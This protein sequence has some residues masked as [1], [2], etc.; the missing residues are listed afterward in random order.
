MIDITYKSRAD[1]ARIL[2]NELTH[3]TKPVYSPDNPKK[4]VGEPVY[5]T[6]IGLD[7]E[8]TT[9][10]HYDKKHYKWIV[11]SCFCYTYQIS[12]GTKYYAI[13]R[14][15]EE[16]IAF[17]RI[18]NQILKSKNDMSMSIG[19]PCAKC[20]IWVANLSHEWSFIK[21]QM[22]N[23]FA[24][25]KCFAKS[26]RDVLY[27]D[28]GRFMLRECIGLFGHSLADIAKNWTTTQ[29]LKGDLD[30]D[31]IRTHETPLSE[32][33]KQYCINDVLILAEMHEAV[34][35]AYKQDNGGVILPNTSSG[36]VRLK[37]KNA[38]RN[39]VDL[40]EEREIFNLNK[41]MTGN[42]EI[43]TNLAYLCRQNK[44]LFYSK[45]QWET[46]RIYAYCGGLCGSNI[47]YVGKT[48]HNIQ[49]VDL[50]SDYPA[51]LLHKKFPSGKL[52]KI[53]KNEFSDA[54]HGKRPF[55]MMCKII[56]MESKT[57]H[58]TF[59]QHKALNYENPV[60]IEHYGKIK[61]MIVY[62]GKIR[63][64]YNVIAIL[65]D[66]DLKSYDM[67]YD[68]Q[69]TPITIY[70]FD[71]YTNIPS[72]LATSI[73]HDYITKSKLKIA[74]LS[75]T[76]E[77]YDSKRNVNT[78]YGV[79][80]TRPSDMYDEFINGIFEPSKEFSYN[81]MRCNTWL[82]PYI[83][84]WC[85]AYARQILMYF[86]S[87]YPDLIVQYDTDSL[88]YI[89]KNGEP[90]KQEIEKY[91]A[92]ITAKNERKFKNNPDK[93]LLMTLGTW[94]FENTYINFLA[95]GAKKYIKQ[96]KE[97][98]IQTVIAGLPKMAIPSEIANEHIKKPFTYYNSLRKYIDT[99]GKNQTIIIKHQYA[100]KF[101]SVYNDTE[102]VSCETITDY[103]GNTAEQKTGCYHAIVPID[104]TLAMKQDYCRCALQLH[105]AL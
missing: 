11:D 92:H 27:C 17:F 96:D 83:A 34:I 26:N 48:L 67:I 37:L 88:Y 19:E 105:N 41:C 79:L 36:F 56:K 16:V 69:F 76:L 47:D 18:L 101:A 30:Y 49:C 73:I 81:E 45:Y 84:F 72:W 39:D 97:N 25:Q 35:S 52:T 61:N 68:L 82:N 103:M 7:T 93:N 55:L 3:T 5:K 46:C 71:R 50:T 43:K 64:A 62:N 63:R 91:N 104:F 94:D 9:I 28:F 54:L 31:L 66:V 59:S 77:Y 75:N 99:D 14:T 58:A 78:Y 57:H 70:R 42:R 33:E 80:A 100:N 90:L 24:L 51:Q 87:K 2:T 44:D 1:V 65:S 95:M 86:I 21:Y 102:F 10:K 6:G 13:Y 15:I 4:V 98:G 32:K 40:S 23:N 60:Y 8:S 53:S 38:I 12:I 85:T 74:G 22:C 89:T 20:W 29:K